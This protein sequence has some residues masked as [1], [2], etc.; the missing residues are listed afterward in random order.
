M[1]PIS[2]LH[3]SLGAVSLLLLAACL[4]Q[5]GQPVLTRQQLGYDRTALAAPAG[6]AHLHQ[7][8][9]D[10]AREV[11]MGYV[12]PRPADQQQYRACVA[13]TLRRAVARVRSPALSA[14]HRQPSADVTLLGRI[15]SN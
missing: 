3:A 15:A 4:V 9:V 5:A 1:N 8:L 10:A 7:R 14:Y 13:Q 6:V 2:R 11:C 12:G